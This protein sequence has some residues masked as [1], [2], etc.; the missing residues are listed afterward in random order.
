MRKA[1]AGN[2]PMSLV[3][4]IFIGLFAL[5]AAEVLVLILVAALIGWRW[6]A[7]LFVATS[8]A[9]VLL[10]KRSGGA[11]RNRWRAAV[12]RHGIR[13]AVLES[14]G[15]A[16]GLGGIL[17]IFPG[18]IT[19]VLGLALCVPAL[20][21]WAAGKLATLARNRRRE[22]RDDRIIDLAPHEWHQVPDRR[23]GRRR[24]SKDRT[25]RRA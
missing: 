4:W 14:P 20:R 19:D 2:L 5:P 16:T 8:L 15:V 6:T 10:L 11:D 1:D 13:P 3:K 18:F 7:M 17:L 22:Q 9:G 12:A 23:R 21:R 25:K 24:A